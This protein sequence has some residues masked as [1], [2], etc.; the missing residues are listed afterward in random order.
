MPD[1][2]Q[3]HELPDDVIATPSR[4]PARRAGALVEGPAS[5]PS[6]V[7]IDGGPSSIARMMMSATR[8]VESGIGPRGEIM[9]V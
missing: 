1:H 9:S 7:L 4:L 3:I 6:V 8:D 5:D 2:G